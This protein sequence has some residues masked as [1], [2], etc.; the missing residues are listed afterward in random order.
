MTLEVHY[1]CLPVCINTK[2][3]TLYH[4][5]YFRQ[6]ETLSTAEA[7]DARR[8]CVFV[9]IFLSHANASPSFAFE[10]DVQ[11]RICLMWLIKAEIR[12]WQ[13]HP[14]MFPALSR[15]PASGHS[16]RS[17]DC[18]T[19]N[20][21]FSHTQGLFLNKRRKINAA[22]CILQEKK[23]PK[24]ASYRCKGQRCVRCVCMWWSLQNRMCTGL[25]P[26]KK[27]RW[28]ECKRRKA[29]LSSFPPDGL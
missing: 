13:E 23:T 16:V 14:P 12:V 27:N 20:F 18:S 28:N 24:C 1:L 4:I 9:C 6:S 26:E 29:A 25:S 17:W 8:L 7:S 2:Y 21:S 22:R 10:T 3:T 19:G 11:I 15:S 5:W